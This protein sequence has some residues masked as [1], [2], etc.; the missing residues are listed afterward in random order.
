MYQTNNDHLGE[1][2]CAQRHQVTSIDIL[3]LESEQ[4]GRPAGRPA[5][6]RLLWAASEN[7]MK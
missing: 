3:V 1:T 6:A 2:N 7:D 4:Y 5:S